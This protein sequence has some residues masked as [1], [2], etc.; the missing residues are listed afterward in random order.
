MCDSQGI[1]ERHGGCGVPQGY[2]E[3]ALRAR[4]RSDAAG[5]AGAAGHPGNAALTNLGSATM[6]R[7]PALAAVALAPL[8]LAAAARRGPTQD[9]PDPAPP[10]SPP[11]ADATSTTAPS[12]SAVRPAIRPR[13]D[14]GSSAKPGGTLRAIDN[15]LLVVHHTESPE[16]AY[17]PSEVAALIEGIYAFHTSPEVGWPDIG[18]NFIVD[19]FGTIWE[20]RQGSLLAPVACE[21]DGGNPGHSQHC[22]FL[23]NFSLAAPTPL[24]T[25]AMV[26]LLAWLANRDGVP[27]EPG[28]T[29]DFVSEGSDRFPPG[30]K[31]SVRTICGHS[32]ISDVLCPGDAAQ[33]EVTDKLQALVN[34]ERQR[35]GAGAGAT[36]APAATGTALPPAISEDEPAT[37]L[38]TTPVTRREVGFE[39]SPLPEVRERDA[40][41]GNRWA[42]GVITGAVAAAAVGAGAA[43][44]LR[45][46]RAKAPTQLPERPLSRAALASG[47]AARAAAEA[48]T[49]DAARALALRPEGIERGSTGWIPA[50][51][52]AV[53]WAVSGGWSDDA[54][55][56]ALRVV[57][58]LARSLESGEHPS[59]G[60][61]FGEAVTRAMAHLVRGTPGELDRAAGQGA[62]AVL[63][64]HSRNSTSVVRLGS[65]GLVLPGEGE[66]PEWVEVRAQLPAGVG[67]GQAEVTTLARQ[68]RHPDRLPVVVAWL[69]PADEDEVIEALT[70]AHDTASADGT[71]ARPEHVRVDDTTR[72]LHALQRAGVTDLGLVV[73]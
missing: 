63:F 24:A 31:V 21:I 30:S 65:G 26:S 44:A 8:A 9:D 60:R 53:G 19:E 49:I 29:T 48:R 22:A 15:Q 54:H 14:W 11:D 43:F 38:D 2:V 57:R 62:G 20:G 3:A 72:V 64:L 35:T 45:R 47:E 56:E 4:R 17:E 12:G 69:G 13:D 41:T 67:G 70:T 42:P 16:G 32:E 27:T 40:L 18:F 10:A 7:R 51:D 6:G 25:E 34:G 28:D 23:G 71:S 36:D 33:A 58:G 37:T 55:D 59:E 1:Q 61:A 46:R 68:W 66:R 50:G 39:A 5:S 52:A 73:L